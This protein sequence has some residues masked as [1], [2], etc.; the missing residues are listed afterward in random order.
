MGKIK[1][2]KKLKT[3]EP[4]K[5]TGDEPAKE[6]ARKSQ[7]EAMAFYR[8]EGRKALKTMRN[9]GKSSR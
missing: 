3:I 2:A 4:G 5:S 8:T 1:A 7:A 9:P 6:R